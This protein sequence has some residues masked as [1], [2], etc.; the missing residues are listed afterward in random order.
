MNLNFIAIGIISLLPIIIGY[1]WYHPN[2]KISNW[3]KIDFVDYR[4]IK[5]K[6]IIALIILSAILILGY[7]NIVIH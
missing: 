7:I 2:S 5:I 6:Q 3:S 1:F 4:D